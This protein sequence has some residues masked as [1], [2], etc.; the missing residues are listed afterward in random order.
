MQSDLSDYNVTDISCDSIT[1]LPPNNESSYLKE[2]IGGIIV[3]HHCFI[4]LHEC[5]KI[6]GN[7]NVLI[8][9]LCEARWRRHYNNKGIIVYNIFLFGCFK[10]VPESFELVY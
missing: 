1:V 6:F 9:Q 4:K 10:C 3:F 2:F 5:N 7:C 8:K